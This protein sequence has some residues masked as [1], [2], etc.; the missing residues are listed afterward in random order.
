MKRVFQEKL[1][2]AIFSIMVSALLY[3]LISSN[4]FI[5]GNDPAVHLTKAIEIYTGARITP[6][7]VAWYPPLYRILLATFISFANA[8]FLEHAVFLMKLLTVFF[9]WLLVSAVYLLGRRL[10]GPECG[11]MASALLLLCF[12]FYEINFWGGYSSLLSIILLCI[13]FFY[14]PSKNT[15]LQRAVLIFILAFS[16]ILTHQ[17]TTFIA[18]IIIGL[19]FLIS[20]VAFKASIKKSLVTAILGGSVAFLIWYLPVILPH[21]N[22]LFHHTFISQTQYL[23]LVWRV[24]YDVFYLN[25]GFVLFLSFAGLVSA[26]LICRRNN[27]TAFYVLLLL[28]FIAPLLLTQSY[29]VGLMLPYDRFVYYMMPCA[30]VLASSV[31]CLFLRFAV[32]YVNMVGVTLKSCLTVLPTFFLVCLLLASR[33]P[34][35]PDKISEATGYYSYLDASGYMASQWLLKSFPQ[36]SA[37]VTTEKPGIFFGLMSKKHPFMETN[38]L[39]ERS[40]LAETVL[41]LAF[42][43]EHPLTLYRVFEVP[44]PYEL[45]QYNI[46]IHNVWKRVVFLYPEDT[47]VSYVVDG[48]QRLKLLSDLSKR[49]FW[50]KHD[51][52]R[53]LCIQYAV[54][55]NFYLTQMVEMFNGSLPVKVTWVPACS[56]ERFK[57]FSVLLSLRFDPN[58]VFNVT[59][60]PGLFHWEN[61]I[62]K[63]LPFMIEGRN[64]TTYNFSP[65]DL[66]KDPF[67]FRDPV[68]GVYCALMF[69]HIPHLASI[70]ILSTGQVD[71]FRFN[72]SSKITLGVAFSYRLL[73]FSEE[74]FRELLRE[75][76]PQNFENFFSM[77][78]ETQ[79]YYRDYLT[80][81]KTSK[82]KFVIF[83][84]GKFRDALLNSGLLH[85]IYSTDNYVVCKVKDSLSG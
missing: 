12:P 58:F 36:E 24:T 72:Y 30:S 16:M 44:M 42:E 17:F 59:Y 51:A 64:W 83:E 33:F 20:I 71:A 32:F 48:V 63:A 79:F 40:A 22:I 28:G 25:F 52:K 35:L 1:F 41:N 45:D 5:L 85:L 77:E 31:I 13:L 80:L 56:D 43:L 2:F 4:G 10:H 15:N 49:I 57:E 76:P 19:Y 8:P 6:S 7:E 61:P 47:R 55:E 81:I 23:Y 75:F 18:T 26:F 21:I 66:P 37:V 67:V 70:G 78:T 69:D 34:A 3:A 84:R 68:N 60:V 74:S 65:A 50:E 62:G 54:D 11:I 27:E 9:D 39:V 29:K 53:V 73:T 14:L 82:I 46:L 38:P